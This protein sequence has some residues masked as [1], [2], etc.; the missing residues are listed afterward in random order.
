[1]AHTPDAAESL[2]AS[3]RGHAL[4]EAT[5]LDAHSTA[6]RPE[7]EAIL[8]SVG[9]RQGWLVLDAGCGGGNYL[10]L[11]T[12][13]IGP[14][15]HLA[16]LDLAPENTEAV[17]ARLVRPTRGQRATAC[18]GSGILADDGRHDGGDPSAE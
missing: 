3:S 8:R 5:W 12:E 16:A 2:H 10:P 7:N 9:L 4:A 14:T 11:I 6:K 1:M 17:E 18:G 15:R 13:V